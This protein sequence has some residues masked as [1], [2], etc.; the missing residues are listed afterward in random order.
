MLLGRSMPVWSNDDIQLHAHERRHCSL[1][2]TWDEARL[3]TSPSKENKSCRKWYL[4]LLWFRYGDH[5][6][7]ALRG[8][9]INLDWRWHKSEEVCFIL[10]S[11]TSNGWKS[12]TGI[13]KKK[14]PSFN[15]YLIYR[16]KIELKLWCYFFF[17]II[18]FFLIS[19][20]PA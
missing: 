16:F 17:I 7:L 14:K 6:H 18:D 11:N 5:L 10:D 12:M 15:I 13:R 1:F 3:F 9:W 4:H 20:F 2:W 8:H 19:L